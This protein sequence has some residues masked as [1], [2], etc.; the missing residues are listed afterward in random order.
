M[1]YRPEHPIYYQLLNKYEG[2][3]NYV[4]S[5][6]YIEK[7]FNLG[8]GW[9]LNLPSIE[10]YITTRYL[11][12]TDEY[13]DIIIHEELMDVML[14]HLGNGRVYR[15]FDYSEYNLGYD[16]YIP[17][18]LLK[19]LELRKNPGTF[20]NGQSSSTHALIYKDGKKVY[21]NS[22]GKAI[23]EEDRYGNRIYYYYTNN[24]LTKIKDTLDR[25]IN[26]TYYQN[27]GEKKVTFKG[28]D[29]LNIELTFEYLPQYTLN[30]ENEFVLK[31]IKDQ[32]NRE[33]IFDYTIASG[34]F[35]FSTDPDFLWSEKT[36]YFANLTKVTYPT[37]ATSSYIYEK[38]SNGKIGSA[39]TKL[40]YYRIKTRE[41]KQNGLTYNQETYTYEGDYTQ[42]E[43]YHTTVKNTENKETRY[44]FNSENLNTHRTIRKN[45]ILLE[46]ES[47]SY[48][49]NTLLS[50]Q[51]TKLYD[52]DGTSL[53]KQKTWQY[54]DH[55][56]LL[57]HTNE[58]GQI[59][60]YQYENKF[61]Q[62]TSQ[63]IQIDSTRWR[64][65]E[66]NINSSN[67]NVNWTKQHNIDNGVDKSITTYFT[68]D[69]Y[70]NPITKKIQKPDG[71]FIEES[72]EYSSIYRSGYLTKKTSKYK[73]YQG[74]QQTA[75]ENMTYDFNTGRLL[76]LTDGNLNTTAFQYDN[77]GRV[78]QVSNP[79]NSKI[80]IAF[81]DIQNIVTATLENNH[82]VRNLYDGLGRL[83][84]KQETKNGQW[85]TL[86]EN[87]Y[88]TLSRID[89]TKD[90]KGNM[91]KFEYDLFNR[92]TKIINPDISKK[93]IQYKD[94][95]NKRIEINEEG[96]QHLFQYDNVGNLIMEEVKPNSNTIYRNHY[97]YDL[98]GNLKSRKDPKGNVTRFTYDT[99]GRLIKVT[100]PKNEE[101]SYQY[102][103]LNNLIK[104]LV[105]E[106]DN[107]GQ[108]NR[109]II[110][111]K[112]YDD[113]GRLIKTIDPLGK[114]EYYTYD[115]VGNLLQK[116]DK[117]GQKLVNTYDKRNR[118]LTQTCYKK[119][120]SVESQKTFNYS[121]LYTQNKLTATDARGT[122]VYEY[123]PN[124]ALKKETQPD[125]KYVTYE[126]DNN[127]NRS[128]LIDPY[129]LTI[130]YTYDSRNRLDLLTINGSKTFDYD[131]YQ[132]GMIKSLKYP[133]AIGNSTFTYDDTNRL[134]S[135]SNAAG[136]GTNHYSYQ[137]DGNSNIQSVTA[138]GQTKLYQ[139]DT[140]NRLEMAGT[141]QVT[142]YAYDAR[143]NRTQLSGYVPEFYYNDLQGNN[144]HDFQYNVLNQLTQ[145]KID[146]TTILGTYKYNLDGLRAEKT[147]S[148]GTTKYYYDNMGRTLSE[149]NSSSS[150]TAQVV[151]GHKPLARII[152]NQY[153]YYIY[154][155][156]G[157]VVQVINQNGV[158]VNSYEYDEWGNIIQKQEQINN[159]IRY[160]GEYYDDESGLY[161]LRA[162]YYDPFIGRFITKDSY[163]GQLTNPMSMNQY[164]YCLNNP[165]IFIDKSGNEP[166]SIILEYA[167]E[168]LDSL[169]NLVS[170]YGPELAQGLQEAG[171]WIVQHGPQVVEGVKN[172]AKNVTE[173]LKD[174]VGSDGGG[175][176]NLDPNK[177]DKGGSNSRLPDNRSIDSKVTKEL[178]RMGLDKKFQ[179]AM[180]KGLAP[181]REGTSGIIELTKNEMITKNGIEYTYKI[182][183][184]TAGGHTRVYG[185]INDAGELIFDLLMKK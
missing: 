40:E 92:V 63:E 110:T 163:E 108:L 70:G 113:L 101:V 158:V 169:Q 44:T 23:G 21:F 128:K 85:L 78:T 10:Q 28:P 150:V 182:K 156:H 22:S 105:L 114:T 87:H 27:G 149:A 148:Q 91:T 103:N 166:I 16:Y 146:G 42:Y 144:K 30:D 136:S 14:L 123:Y 137:Y 4:S 8:V 99:L 94:K 121:Q 127:G 65:T 160:A 173:K 15:A 9:S 24:L 45:N 58:R 79:D 164:V 142:H 60:N 129:G 77:I 2:Y 180:D 5:D 178:K 59:T 64:K 93:Q 71:T 52:A 141:D 151:W 111:Q 176:S 18:Y 57:R 62:L 48:F 124:S 80:L 46:D 53:T 49:K 69:Q 100:N 13:G 67:G 75:V 170:T 102:D 181:R 7:Q 39:R 171:N 167:P 155:G 126:Y 131:Y 17:R 122:T 119:D 41:D 31:K 81:D 98:T 36:N 56:D 55:G 134:T 143:G 37:G 183:V 154:N 54:N 147:T 88:D 161:Y 32:M 174:L 138:N 106:Y 97:E 89:W 12:H 139:Y 135:L 3:R 112:E 50:S 115:K 84:K 51:I 133:N 83:I 38:N 29:N 104:I 25:E 1:G 95:E 145:I 26:I 61:H 19:G 140:L 125:N 6:T 132:D 33:T 20:S 68:Y 165:L 82:Q 179:N 90:A 76:T 175:S 35:N 162:R 118:P 153:Y 86:E 152:N 177:F 72:Y 66:Y 74:N 159:P 130:T 157:D 116:I 109:Q 107:T 184:P 120:S 11:P 34:K 73:D 96:A 172:T 168:A 43:D 47:Y 117:M 185:Y